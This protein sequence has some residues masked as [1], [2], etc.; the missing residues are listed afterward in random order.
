MVV[1]IFL[2][3][4]GF[5]DGVEWQGAY[6]TWCSV[7]FFSNIT[8]CW[9]NP[10]IIELGCKRLFHNNALPHTTW[11]ST[12]QNTPTHYLPNSPLATQYLGY[13][14]LMCASQNESYDSA[15]ETK[16]PLCH[17]FHCT[18][19]IKFSQG[20]GTI[21][22]NY[23]FLSGKVIRT[24]RYK[25]M[26]TGSRGWTQALSLGCW[27]RILVIILT[28]QMQSDAQGGHAC[29]GFAIAVVHTTPKVL[30]N[31]QHKKMGRCHGGHNHLPQLVT[32]LL[33]SFKPGWE[34]IYF[35]L[36]WKGEMLWLFCFLN[37]RKIMIVIANQ[38]VCSSLG[39]ILLP[40]STFNS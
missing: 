26:D 6:Y 18:V 13:F 17:H 38:T 4:L 37:K 39:Q 24:L 14:W 5:R 25:S 36:R 23:L 22:Y 21:L 35:I 8:F 1:I 32:R 15:W 27:Y 20:T 7:C 3:V 16:T 2:T 29:Q 19:R 12:E 10:S 11:S 33:N 9:V 34:R 30:E 40:L 31:I 28:P